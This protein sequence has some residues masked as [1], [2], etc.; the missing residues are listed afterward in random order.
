MISVKGEI[1]SQYLFLMLF[2]HRRPTKQSFKYSAPDISD[3]ESERESVIYLWEG[4]EGEKNTL[5]FFPWR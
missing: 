5:Y 3:Y 4:S 1:E 2:H